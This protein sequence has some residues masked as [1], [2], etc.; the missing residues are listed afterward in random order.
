MKSFI[1]PHKEIILGLE[2]PLRVE[3]FTVISRVPDVTEFR[4]HGEV[5]YQML[6]SSEI[7][8]RWGT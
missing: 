6:E 2:A 4:Y 8:G 7:R 3:S 5:E 1:S